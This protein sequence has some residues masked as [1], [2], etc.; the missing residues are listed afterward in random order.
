VLSK[1]R[2]T[3]S[4]CCSEWEG[5]SLKYFDEGSGE[6]KGESIAFWREELGIGSCILETVFRASRQMIM[7]CTDNQQVV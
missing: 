7:R 4:W 1:I 6:N 3:D 2:G 5:A